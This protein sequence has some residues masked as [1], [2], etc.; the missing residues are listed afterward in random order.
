MSSVKNPKQKK[1]L[2]LERERRNRYGENNK[3][4]R[5]AIPRGKQLRHM[6]ERRS[7][8]ELLGRLKGAVQHDQAADAEL[9]VKTRITDSRRRGFKKVPD[10]PLSAVLHKRRLKKN[11]R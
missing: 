2:T 11:Q 7:V 3:A 4:S 6:D 8:N 10:V 1:Q 9:L 5:K